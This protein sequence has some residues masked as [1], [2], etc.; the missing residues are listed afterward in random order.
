MKML[1]YYFRTAL[2]CALLGLASF[3]FTT[4]S[5]K[6][7]PTATLVPL[8]GCCFEV[9]YWIPNFEANRW[10]SC[11]IIPGAGNV[12]SA[13]PNVGFAATPTPNPAVTFTHPA[14]TGYFPFGANL[15]MG[16]VCF[17]LVGPAVVI[18]RFIDKWG[19]V[20]NI[21]FQINCGLIAGGLPIAPI[22]ETVSTDATTSTSGAG[23]SLASSTESITDNQLADITPNPTS[24]NATV[25]LGLAND[26]DNVSLYVSDMTGRKML[27]ITTGE[28]LTMGMHSFN[29]ET[30]NLTSGVYYVVVKSGQFTQAKM[31]QVIK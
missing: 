14:G 18:I 6:A 2:F 17:N 15:N 19:N 3:G 7:N 16:V 1:N 29:V 30:Q 10:V 23:I 24:D 27:D 13:G 5:A 22:G 26:M 25:S 28:R 8:G 20:V 11:T 12:Q 31:L 21:P 4:Q 9:H